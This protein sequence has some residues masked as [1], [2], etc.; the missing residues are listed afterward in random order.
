MVHRTISTRQTPR[1]ITRRRMSSSVWGDLFPKS[2]R[3]SQEP[4]T[5][6]RFLEVELRSTIHKR[7][8][9][10]ERASLWYG[11]SITVSSS[12]WIHVGSAVGVSQVLNPSTPPLVPELLLSTRLSVSTMLD[13]PRAS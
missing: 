6:W 8:A 12:T 10:S 5:F 1:M 11:I 7:D 13:S 4:T 3:S 2:R 9:D